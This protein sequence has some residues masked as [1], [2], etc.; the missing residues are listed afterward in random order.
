MSEKNRK[1]FYWLFKVLSIAVACAFPIWAICEKFPIWQTSYGNA[2]SIG[3]G[4][5]LVLIVFIIIFRTSV[6]NFL[7]DKLN[8]THAPPLVVWL[9]LIAVSYV[10]IFIGQ[11]MQDLVIMLW[12]GLIGCSIGTVLTY[13][14][15]HYFTE[16]E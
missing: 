16:K 15:E 7:R 10:L 3:V 14:A 1:T 13:V 5:I 4:G 2:H 9:I 12:M 11:F 6:F 8:I